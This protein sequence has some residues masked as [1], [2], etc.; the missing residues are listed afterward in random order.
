MQKIVTI[1]GFLFC[2][3]FATS[4]TGTIQGKIKTSDGAPAEYIN[5]TVKGTTLGTTANSKGAYQIRN[6]K[7]GDATLVVSFIGLNTK[8]IIIEVKN[9]EITVIPEIV[10]QENENQL[11]E[12]VISTKNKYRVK[13]NFSAS[14]MDMKIIE[15]PGSVQTITSQTIK[16]Q[17]I[18]TLTEAVK[19]IPGINLFSSYSDYSM[20]GFR[21]GSGYS[22]ENLSVNGQPGSLVSYD[23][24]P[25]SFN[26]ETID[27][28]KGPASVLFSRAT[29]GGV[30]NI[31]TKQPKA[32]TRFEADFTYGS[33]D[34]YRAMFDATGAISKNKKML[35]RMIVGYED[36]KTLRDYE[37]NKTL[38][39]APSILYNFSDNTNYK[40][41]LNY[42]QLD[43]VTSFDRG[44]FAA[45]RTDGTYD[46]RA[47]PISWSRHSAQ[48]ENN[49]R[50]WSI[51]S[52]LNHKF[53][54]NFSLHLLNYYVNQ[55]NET[56]RALYGSQSPILATDT[57]LKNRVSS[58]GLQ[59]SD[60]PTL[61][62]NLYAQINFDTGG[63]KHRSIVG[64]DFITV[65]RYFEFIEYKM[66]DA[67]ISNPDNYN[68]RDETL[69]NLK[70]AYVGNEKSIN[71]GFYFQ[72][73]IIFSPKLKALVGLRYD[74]AKYDV[75]YYFNYPDTKTVTETDKSDAAAFVP[76][77]GL[78]YLPTEN[79]SVYFNYSQSFQPQFSNNIAAGG[80][81]DPERGKQFELGA[82]KSVLKNKVDFTL[83][84][85]HITKNNVL[86]PDPTDTSGIRQ[87]Q[88]GEVQSKGMELVAQG[89][90]A[91]GLNLIAGYSYNEAKITKSESGDQGQWNPMAPK[92]TWSVWLKYN[93]QNGL[94]KNLGFGVGSNYVGN[95]ITYSGPDFVLP[96]YTVVD[97]SVSYKYKKASI[98]LNMYNL[99]NK[100]YFPGAFTSDRIFAGAPRSFRL[101]LNYT[102]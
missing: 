77:A 80:P 63:I 46:F 69:G 72:D 21:S 22:N 44:I 57:M 8:E 56:P 24:V 10:L 90:L 65:G 36:T 67:P 29:P 62:N 16:D 95:R 38:F 34:Q 88:Q 66:P 45:Q 82:K 51:Q 83:A 64:A 68:D 52:Q 47:V 84:L 92:N 41:E 40:V 25:Q 3:L 100:L 54:E 99:A 37:R 13:N 42:H 98:G 76:R 31:T 6:V 1:I 5:I 59:K 60:Y 55:F 74:N 23:I 53:N 58:Y 97:A 73:Q 75:K 15:I 28:I 9:N 86:T 33:F 81:F 101:N 19:N 93:V 89:E 32:D 20:R 4:Q 78:V 71:W 43:A 17:Q 7:I 30:L 14:R 85:Y 35:A 26:I 48:G 102:F 2:S 12:V 91:R 49:V 96:E 11:N 70:D 79:S 94:F 50:N 39:I 61:T 27:A 18:N 87:T